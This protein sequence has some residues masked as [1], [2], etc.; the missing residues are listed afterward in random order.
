MFEKFTDRARK[1][2][3]LANIE[4]QRFNHDY[5]GPEH[6]LLGLI[7]EGSGIAAWVLK[8]FEINILEVRLEIEKL[9]RAFPEKHIMGHIPQTPLT[10]EVL[11]QAVIESQNLNHNYVGTEHILLG[12]LKVE[13]IACQVLRNLGASISETRNAVIHRVPT[14]YVH[15]LEIKWKLLETLDQCA[16]D[17][18]FINLLSRLPHVVTD[19]SIEFRKSNILNEF[20]NALGMSILDYIKSRRN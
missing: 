15:D 5:I 1:I 4:A 20:K 17:K 10:K 9:V 18:V 13:S 7:K 6:I 3:H 16:L 2:L 12:L 19:E 14:E 11:S 8:N